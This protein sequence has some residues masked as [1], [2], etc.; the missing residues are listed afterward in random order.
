MLISF[1][2]NIRQTS[3]GETI[4]IDD[5]FL[6]VKFKGW[7]KPVLQVRAE[8]DKKKR[9]EL[10]NKLLPYVTISG[11]FSHRANAGLEKH[12]GLICIDFDE[13]E[14][15][16]ILKCREALEADPYT[17]ACILSA[18][19]NGLAVI[20]K[21]DP[22]Q[23]LKAF[24][25]L[26]RYYA[27]KYDLTA[28]KACKDVSRPRYVSVDP[29][30][31]E[32][33][34][35][36]LFKDYIK[37]EPKKQAPVYIVSQ[38]DVDQVICQLE[39][40]N[41]DLT[42]GDYER[43]IKIGFGLSEEYGEGGREY[44]HRIVRLNP[45]YN[46]NKVSKQFDKCLKGRGSGVS[47][48][49]F[50]YYAK[51]AGCQLI[52]DKTKHIV[53]VSKQA[54][55]GGRTQEQALNALELLSEIP[56]AEAQDVVR[57]VFEKN[58]DLRL[59]NELSMDEQLQ[60]FLSEEYDIKRNEITR[61][62]EN[63]GTELDTPE[64]NGIFIHARKVVSDKVSFELL[65]RTINSTLTPTYNPIRDF[66]DV[67]R[68]NTTTGHIK[69]LCEAV[70]TDTGM[71]AGSFRPDYFEYYFTKWAVGI[72][73]S[74]Y[75]DTSPLLLVLTGEKQNTGKTQFFRRLLPG[76][77][78]RFY[79]ESKLDAGKDDDLLMTQK[80]LIMDDEMG[81]KSK[82]ENK[83][84]K[85]LTSKEYFTL[86]EPYGRKNITLKR[87]AILAGTSN[88]N[89]LL[90]DPTG[91]RRIIPVHVQEIDFEKYNSVDKTALFMELVQLYESGY[92]WELTNEDIQALS[93][94][95]GDFEE[96][97]MEKELILKFFEPGDAL[98]LTAT[99]I[100]EKIESCTVQRIS[101]WKMG[102][103]LT[104]LGFQKVTKKINGVT[105]QVYKVRPVETM[106]APK[107]EDIP[108]SKPIYDRD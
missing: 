46:E 78:K 13:K 32:N 60:L 5:F 73:A 20:A 24:L 16:D 6:K 54:K 34:K 79:A 4:S 17:F 22:E 68:S 70:K 74:I 98:E 99:E 107:E 18:S 82:R 43:Y 61:Y 19:G 37:P 45:N 92:N 89:T 55:R 96:I 42:Q 12:T 105:K 33:R 72:V 76:A 30:L 97:R 8:K 95:T 81:G 59:D 49:T 27:K 85:E 1:F 65:E 84:L 58:I 108:F 52:S 38:S 101:I 36:K 15:P 21:I 11:T 56:R 87:L 77:L 71:E 91:N 31:F 44:F 50:Y 64:L 23:H 57:Q 40:N 41:I 9:D 3:N 28:D 102:S 47:L 35:S 48:S 2:K 10:K 7:E 66:I 75:G 53:A 26:E 104:G 103:E 25:G 100:K 93:N 62:L 86:R 80:L 67:N 90:S 39:Q 83:R 69:T 88:E 106:S 63:R 51:E 14:N 94:H 29:D